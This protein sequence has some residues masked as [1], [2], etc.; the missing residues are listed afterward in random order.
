MS[1]PNRQW[2]YVIVDLEDGSCIGTDSDDTAKEY[3]R[4]DQN[5]VIEVPRCVIITADAEGTEFSADNIP[6]QKLYNLADDQ[7]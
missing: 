1:I 3:A 5:F 7:G 2:K 4:G 6:E